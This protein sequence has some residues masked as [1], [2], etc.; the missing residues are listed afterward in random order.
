MDF[1]ELVNA[2]WRRKLWIAA[3]TLA[4]LAAAYGALQVVSPKYEAT[5]TL[6]IATKNSDPNNFFFYTTM[7][8][9]VPVYADA[10]TARTTLNEAAVQLG[11]A[12]ADIRVQTFQASPI[13]RIKARS[14]K[15]ALAAAS[16]NAVAKT[17][18]DRVARGE[19]GIPALRLTEVDRASI[20]DAPVFPDRTLTFIVA[21]LLGVALGVGAAL[22][23]ENLATTIDTGDDLARVAGIPSFG[24]IPQ[25]S[26]IGRMGSVE[27]LVD[28]PGLRVVSEAFR[29]VRTNLLFSERDLRSVVV[30]S[31][32]GSHGKTTVAFGLAVT[33]ARAGTRTVLVDADLRRGRV[34]EMLG[35]KR[36]PGLSELLTAHTTRKAAIRSTPL[37]TLD[38]I[39]GGSRPADP[40]ELLTVE[41]PAILKSLEEEYEMVIIDATPAEPVTDARVV[42]RYADATVLVVGA[43]KTSRR[44]VRTAIERLALISVRPTATILNQSKSSR[45]STY[46][47]IDELSD[48]PKSGRAREKPRK[49]ARS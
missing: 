31:P 10:V 14:T 4:V 39:T 1:N 38:I 34:A 23:R 40:G 7:D 6:A 22:M 24:E 36:V 46:Y 29:D 11:R 26:A 33:L 48:G 8:S 2:L 5:A 15:P 30:T 49:A 13:L 9:I 45:G 37:A 3:V 44:Q 47:I 42:A 28:D 18:L 12:P 43:G 21:G 16:A 41:F 27:S 35:V 19:I 32:D 25:E 20:P 17:L